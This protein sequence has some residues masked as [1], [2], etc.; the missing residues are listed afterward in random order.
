MFHHHFRAVGIL[1]VRIDRHPR[2]LAVVEHGAENR[3]HVIESKGRQGDG[4]LVGADEDQLSR[5]FVLL[6]SGYYLTAVGGSG[7][8][9][10]TAGLGYPRTLIPRDPSGFSDP[11]TEIIQAIETHRA[12]VSTGPRLR[13]RVNCSDYHPEPFFTDTSGDV[14]LEL[15]LETPIWMPIT[16]LIIFANGQPA[17]AVSVDFSSA[18]PLG[19]YRFS[20]LF[21]FNFSPNQDTWFVAVARGTES[22]APVYP[23]HAFVVSNPVWVDVDG[24]DRDEDGV[25]FDSPYVHPSYSGP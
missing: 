20:Q 21:Y 9:D 1:L 8:G 11:G 18:S 24:L 15:E 12:V 14:D 4:P 7:A 2:R 25:L 19:G 6:N 23:G 10:L 17:A 16:E 13:Y 3:D 22:L 5:W